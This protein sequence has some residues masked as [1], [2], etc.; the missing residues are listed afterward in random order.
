VNGFLLTLRSLARCEAAGTLIRGRVIGRLLHG[1]AVQ[2]DVEAFALDVGSDAQPDHSVDD[3]E[4][5]QRDDG[6]VDDDD[7]DA[8][9]S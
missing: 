8:Q 6:I 5:D 2:G 4:D 1:L 3:P 9:S 7:D